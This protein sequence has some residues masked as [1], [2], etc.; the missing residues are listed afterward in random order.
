MAILDP[1]DEARSW[2][3]EWRSVCPVTLTYEGPATE[4]G[5]MEAGA[6]SAAIIGLRDIFERA[7]AV[8]NGGEARVTVYVAARSGSWVLATVGLFLWSHRRE[9][10]DGV[11]LALDTGKLIVDA[12][13]LYFR[14]RGVVKSETEEFPR[15][16]E[17]LADDASFRDS[18]RRMFMAFKDDKI[19]SLTIRVRDLLVTITRADLALF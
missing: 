7:N 14:R 4:D 3:D 12:V 6:V 10:V 11:K 9:I 1:G 5:L 19:E 17:E 18:L 16:A 15:G 13:E 8:A 2:N